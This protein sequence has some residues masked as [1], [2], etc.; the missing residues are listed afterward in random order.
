MLVPL[1]FVPPF[2]IVHMLEPEEMFDM[3]FDMQYAVL[4]NQ[5]I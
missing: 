5:N 4:T 2:L 3:S 1:C